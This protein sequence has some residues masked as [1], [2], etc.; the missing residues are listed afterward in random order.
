LE[1]RVFF[2]RVAPIHGTSYLAL[3]LLEC[4]ETF[5]VGSL[6]RKLQQAVG[7]AAGRIAMSW[8]ASVSFAPLSL[9]KT[10]QRGQLKRGFEFA[11]NSVLSK[12]RLVLR[13]P[14]LFGREPV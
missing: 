4:F 9:T 8:R 14:K 6:G 2:N 5:S 13:K 12:R 7:V 1:Y 10:N 11:G 3:N